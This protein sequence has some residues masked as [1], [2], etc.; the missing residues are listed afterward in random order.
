M[1][2]LTN[3]EAY[4]ERT[5]VQP[6]RIGARLNAQTCTS[7]ACYQHEGRSGIVAIARLCD[8][9]KHSSVRRHLLRRLVRVA[10]LV[11]AESA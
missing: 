10:H 11:A 9:A 4:Q 6:A 5:P 1:V 7:R 3:T 2:R 8:I